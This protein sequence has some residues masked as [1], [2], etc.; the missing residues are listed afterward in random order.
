MINLMIV[1]DEPLFRDFLVNFIPWEEYGFN[2]VAQAKNGVE[3]LELADF[4]QPDV[5]LT[6]IN[7]PKMDGIEFATELLK[8]APET[9]VV[10]ITGHNEFEYARK[11][12]R[13]GVSDYILKPFEKEEL[14]L[15][16][17]KIKDNIHEAGTDSLMNDTDL[18]DFIMPLLT[19]DI[20]SRDTK[21]I[22]QAKNL[23]FTDD[24]FYGL[25]CLDIDHLDHRYTNQEEKMLWRFSVM[26]IF[27]E[28]VED[29]HSI[30]SDRVHIFYDYEGNITCLYISDEEGHTFDG[31]F[32][33]V[34]EQLVSSVSK[35]LDFTVT[36]G[37]STIHKGL[38]GIGLAYDEAL[39]ALHHKF[40][41]FNKRII[42]F[43]DV[44]KENR[45]FSWYNASVNENILSALRSRDKDK[46]I[47]D[48]STL[49][50]NMKNH[51]ISFEFAKIIRQG[52]ISLL[53]SHI[54]QS[55][56]SME[57]IFGSELTPLEAVEKADTIFLQQELMEDLYLKTIDYFLENTSSRSSQIALTGKSFI[58]DNYTNSGLTVQDIA[59]AQFINQTY[60]RSMFKKEY[61]MTV[62]DYLTKTRMEN[63]ADLL[64]RKTHR[65][66]DI[67]EMV[68]YNDSSYF[69]KCF[70]K[71]YGVSPSQYEIN[72]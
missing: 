63:A 70:K 28:L 40:I 10:F 19:S 66:A 72:H 57:L 16:L 50:I 6:D 30:D 41:D 39:S 9:S 65:L 58:D 68:G 37:I 7:M 46:L 44:P 13:L 67:A 60:L 27:K 47:Q 23:G 43:H 18:Y 38:S 71:Y 34:M 56:K 35:Y 54:T 21:L 62:S 52:L 29:D 25:A 64:K 53:L 4:H 61:G 5:V 11:A 3:A 49:Y 17:L 42:Y 45:D 36:I 8:L 15:T 69:S 51:H 31:L 59:S 33:S 55:G 2:L 26:N 48:L 12:I 32:S 1:D 20:L 22:N 24:C 14:V